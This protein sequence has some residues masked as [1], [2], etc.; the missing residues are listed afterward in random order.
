TGDHDLMHGENHRGRAAG[1]A[2]HVADVDDVGD[3]GTLAAELDRNHDA[4]QA[5]GTRCRERLIGEPRLGVDDVGVA[6]GDSRRSLRAALD[7]LGERKN[8]A[9]KSLARL[10]RRAARHSRTSGI[11]VG[12]NECHWIG[13]LQYCKC[14]GMSSRQVKFARKTDD[15]FKSMLVNT[16]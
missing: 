9:R 16:E 6:R 10:T 4:E 14:G 2:E 12:V 3:R 1:A 5:L 13:L 15:S 8:L 11:I 7:I